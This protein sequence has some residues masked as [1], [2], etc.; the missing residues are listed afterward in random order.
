[1]YIVLRKLAQITGEIKMGREVNGSCLELHFHYLHIS[2]SLKKRKG[3]AIER[4]VCTVD[5][6]Y[7]WVSIA[8][9]NQANSKLTQLMQLHSAL[10]LHS[11]RPPIAMGW[12]MVRILTPVGWAEDVGQGAW[13]QFHRLYIDCMASGMGH[14][15]ILPYVTCTF[16]FQQWCP[17]REKVPYYLQCTG[18]SE[19]M[20]AEGGGDLPPSVVSL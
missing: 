18:T 10:Q 7:N 9:T 6:N 12:G 19:H 4:N 2:L 5:P 1:M 16:Y 15:H 11:S 20:C 14:N 17:I 3:G 8:N 13:A